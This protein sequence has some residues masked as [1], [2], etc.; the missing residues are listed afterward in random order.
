MSCGKTL[1]LNADTESC[2]ETGRFFYKSL[3]QK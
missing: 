2:A 1:A 3:L